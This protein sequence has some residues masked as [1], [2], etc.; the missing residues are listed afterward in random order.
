VKQNLVIRASAGTGKTFSLATRFLRLMLFQ[1]A[2][3]ERILAL[4]F[5]RAAAQE[6]YTALLRRLWRAAAG[7]AG[8]ARERGIL[9]ADLDAAD[10]AAVAAK[11]I[12]F[13][14]DR[15]R[16]LLRRVLDAQHCGT[17]ATLDSFI[18]RIVRNFPLEMGFQ[19]TVGVL[20]GCGEEK[21]AADALAALLSGGAPD[22]AFPGDFFRAVRGGFVRSC[23]G[24]VADAMGGWRAFRLACRGAC[25]G[26]TASSMRRALGLDPPPAKPSDKAFSAALAGVSGNN[27]PLFEAFKNHLDGFVPEGK[28]FGSN[29]AGEMAR[30]FM[31]HP[32]ATVFRYE[33]GG[34]TKRGP[35][36]KVCDCGAAGAAFVRA[37]VRWM[38]AGKIGCAIDTVRAKL[39]LVRA[40][41][42]VYDAATRRQG[43][44]AFGDFTDAVA[45]KAAGGSTALQ[46]ENLQF[47]FDAAFD[48]WA[49]DEFQDTSAL[50][51]ACLESLVRSAAQEGGGR[52]V[53]AV[54][55]LKQ[56]IYTWRGGDDTPFLE[57]MGW[58]E[59]APPAGEILQNAVSRRYGRHTVGFINRVFGPENVERVFDPA[60]LEKEGIPEAAC[61]KAVER[62]CA[63]ECWMTHEADPARPLPD[64]FVQVLAVEAPKGG[65][66]DAEDGGGEREDD[67]ERRPSAAMR[68]LAPA[69]CAFV[70]DFWEKH[71]ACGSTDTV[72]ILVR[73]N[74]DG[75]ALAE[76]LRAMDGAP[77]VVW[78]GADGILDSP[79]VRAV[80]S[81]LSLAE[82]PQDSF[83]WTFSEELVPLGRLVFP[84]LGNRAKVS[85]AVAA[86]LSRQGLARTLKA[87]VSRIASAPE[88]MRPDARSLRRLK[89]LVREGV[90]YERR[91][92]ADAGI[93]GFR[94]YLGL[95][96]GRETSDSPR[97]IRILTIHR[98]KGLTID[99]VIVPVPEAGTRDTIVQPGGVAHGTVRL[100]DAAAGWAVEG[101]GAEEARLDPVL[102]EAWNRAANGNVLDRLR[103][104]YVALTRARK[105][106]H[107]FVC[108]KE[109]TRTG[110]IQ[111]RD[112]LFAAFPEGTGEGGGESDVAAG[113]PRVRTLWR[114]GPEPDFGRAEGRAPEESPAWVHAEGAA[115]V[116]RRSPSA[117]QAGAGRRCGIPAASLFARGETAAERGTE[118]H[119]KY[120]Q[121]GWIDPENPKDAEER[122]ILDSP[123]RDAF[124][125]PVG[126]GTLW[127]EKG[128]ERLADGAW[129]T[130]RFDRVVFA[131]EGSARRAAVYDFKGGRPL[132]G[133]TEEAFAERMRG[134][135]REQMLSYRRAVAAL[136]GLG[137][138]NVR[139]VLLLV[140][141]RSCVEI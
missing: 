72:A 125:A 48:H 18:L 75:L 13:S 49:L 140:A 15:F 126:G 63:P 62:W 19:R 31:E 116:A 23:A 40:A 110:K 59:F 105:S 44:L 121:I 122:A 109:A 111:F 106:T 25:D 20:D 134:T 26:W 124:V 107:V 100:H 133:E 10:R 1:D 51:W 45:A 60:R 73:T 86:M 74:G 79:V 65:E 99:H 46:L 92:A 131:G 3:P 5:S 11:G 85:K 77:P 41:E 30:F 119:A 27:R 87:V 89:A 16:T 137:E 114:A 17:I 68:V 32:E 61:R 129:E 115:R 135:Y 101:I 33:T 7:D 47:R 36:E 136:A 35:Q 38:V 81:L 14:A 104:C 39:A 52:S 76:R 130:G 28:V 37:A 96:A 123:W 97:V 70:K 80:L 50:Q 12:D 8:A 127:R 67:E 24:T 21:A 22:G 6:I 90:A 83:A 117:E 69:V 112:L 84:G 102:S 9:L 57:L 58:A 120:A 139:A 55:D 113:N 141:T 64:D 91:A 98:A 56:S 78:E 138:G 42:R 2:K 29:K 95:A 4:T 82:H 103:L 93:A 34:G 53:M 88:G 108:E 71:E 132:E 94:E 43:L 128:Y 66:G 118:L 54:G